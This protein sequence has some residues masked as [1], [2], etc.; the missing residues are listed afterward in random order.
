[1]LCHV[2]IDEKNICEMWSDKYETAWMY[3]DSMWQKKKKGKGMH[4]ALL[5]VERDDKAL[6]HDGWL[7]LQRE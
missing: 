2:T 6:S 7:D 5:E 1:M 3:C 4:K